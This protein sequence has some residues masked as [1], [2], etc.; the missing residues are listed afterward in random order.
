[1]VGKNEAVREVRCV[2]N[3]RAAETP[4]DDHVRGEILSK[5]CPPADGGG[6]DEEESV[7]GRRV[8]AVHLLVSRDLLFPFCKIVGGLGRDPD[9]L[10]REREQRGKSDEPGTFHA[11]DCQGGK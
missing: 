11:C 8:R 9:P 6:T 2:G 4:I 10:K 5:A 7:F 3:L 1:M